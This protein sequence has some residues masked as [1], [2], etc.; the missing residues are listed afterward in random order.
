MR[1]SKKTKA[2]T[3]KRNE[4]TINFGFLFIGIKVELWA[5]MNWGIFREEG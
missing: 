2:Y 3:R 4:R 1:S 5:G